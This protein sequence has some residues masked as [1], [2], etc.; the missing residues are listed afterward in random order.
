[1]GFD[2]AGVEALE[3]YTPTWTTSGT[4]PT[5]GSS[6][7][8][9]AFGRRG[10]SRMV[11]VRFRLLAGAGVSFGTGTLRF[12]YPTPFP[13]LAEYSTYGY[14]AGSATIFDGTN[15]F[16]RNVVMSNASYFDLRDDANTAV[17]GT[18]PGSMGN[19]DWIAGQ[20]E[21]EADI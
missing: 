17:S 8:V 6:F 10:D 20:F 1:M 18:V 5:L 15:R 9:G 16:Y 7:L 13:P 3:D 19:G 14:V 12:S 4:A 11:V 21:Y 2:G